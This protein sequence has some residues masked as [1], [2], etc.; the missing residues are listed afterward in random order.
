MI[1]VGV[2]GAC[3]RMGL[4]VCRAVADADDMR[5]VAAIDRSKLGQ[6]IGHM[7]GH[8]EVDVPVTDELDRILEAEAELAIDF[9]HPDVV[10]DTVRWCISHAVHLVA[11]TTGISQE[12]LQEIE[13]LLSD[14]GHESNVV[15]APNFALGAV[16]MQRFAAE[17]ARYLPAVEIIEL[18]HDQKA[19]A[20]SGTAIATAR[21]IQH[22]RPEG[23]RG[24]DR[25]EPRGRSG[26]RR[27]WDPRA[28]RPAPRAGGAPGGH[29]RRAGPD[30]DDPP[31]LDRSVL[32]HARRADGGP[33]GDDPAW[34]YRRARAAAR[35]AAAAWMTSAP[36]RRVAC[37]FAHPDDDTF[38][39]GGS[40]ALHA[41]DDLE[42]TAILATSGE[43]GRI[44]D[45][46]LATRGKLGGVREAEDLAS[47]RALGLEPDVRFHR[48]PDGGL[49]RIPRAE[50]AAELAKVLEDV[51][52][53]VV[54][55][56]GPDGITGHPDHVAI[57]AAATD[58]F[59][60]ARRS[61]PERAFARLLHVAVPAGDLD[62]LNEG[63]RA[64]GLE[65]IDSTQPFMPRPVPDDRIG[66]RVDCSGVFDR[67]LEALR[68]HK[69]QSELEDVPF[70][71]WPTMLG[72]EAFVIAWPEYGGD[73]PVFAD[74][75]E[76]L[77][78][79]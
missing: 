60:S 74:L 52:P 3:G 51:A 38:G 77:A 63:L 21:R 55:T 35:T 65:P 16:L 2:I 26:R 49:A 11:G 34:A 28:L 46:S 79:S 41:D 45:P 32:V 53:E 10:M 36:A 76:G 6:P 56:F 37:V 23:W 69:T 7:I 44:A 73:Q 5:L 19:D 29:L 58:A 59:A 68:A 13:K 54:V 47:W 31:R 43:A 27:R 24:P 66:V 64:R 8:P 39:V 67:K 33:G 71:L 62:R 25:G 61:A 42:L 18:H 4:M 70:D 50:L 14:E 48:H 57:G 12:D 75:F 17:A 72:T 40:L 20:P 1:R 30:P 78:A 15:V 9:T 22:D